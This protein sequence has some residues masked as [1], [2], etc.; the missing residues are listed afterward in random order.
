MDEELKN[1][2]KRNLEASEE[3]LRIL[4]KLNR[5]RIAD[6]IYWIVKWVVIIGLSFGA[7]YYIEPFIKKYMDL[8]GSISSHGVDKVGGI[9]NM[10][11]VGFADL[12]DM[13]K[14]GKVK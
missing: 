5:A 8:V 9:S 1:L 12:L 13:I 11:D 10:G 6:N 14:A 4:K 3:S 7:Y 2:L